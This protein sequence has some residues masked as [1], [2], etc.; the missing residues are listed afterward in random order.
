MSVSVRRVDSLTEFKDYNVRDFPC[1]TLIE[2]EDIGPCMS[3]LCGLVS[4]DGQY[5]YENSST[6]Y[7]RPYE[8]GTEFVISVK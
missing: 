8:V 6:V 3:V 5:F 2:L 1:G 4:L 7:A